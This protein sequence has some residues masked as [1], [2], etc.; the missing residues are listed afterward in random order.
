MHEV[1]HGTSIDVAA[2][3]IIVD[4]SKHVAPTLPATGRASWSHNSLYA[5]YQ[6]KMALGGDLAHLRVLLRKEKDK[7]LRGQRLYLVH[8]SSS[9]CNNAP[10]F[11]ELTQEYDKTSMREIMYQL[12]SGNEVCDSGRFQNPYGL[13]I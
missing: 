11:T 5:T 2:S 12:P 1:E 10:F 13:V 3:I 7:Q 8:T 4:A 6:I 9:E